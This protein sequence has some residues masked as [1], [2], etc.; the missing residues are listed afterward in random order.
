MEH[1]ESAHELVSF[2]IGELTDLRLSALLFALVKDL[3]DL[4][5]LESLLLQSL[6]LLLFLLGA[7]AED[8]DFSVLRLE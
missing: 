1:V 8:A 4:V 3:V 5:V 7:L 6:A 2:I